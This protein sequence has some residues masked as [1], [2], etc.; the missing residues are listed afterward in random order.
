MKILVVDDDPTTRKVLSLYLKAKGHEVV[1]AENGLDALE[2]LGTQNVNLI[3]SDVN[4][5]Y[6]DGIEFVRNVRA[7]TE[8]SDIPILMVSTEADQD[9][10]Q[11]AFTAGANGYLIKPVTAEMV[12]DKIKELVR[13]IFAQG[14][15]RNA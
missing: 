1:T 4:M 12:N 14:R 13:N 3:M 5:P 10:Q 7:N 11:L 2:K 9:E 6:M 15:T 8:W